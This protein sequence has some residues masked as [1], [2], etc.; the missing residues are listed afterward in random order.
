MANAR[1]RGWKFNKIYKVSPF[2]REPFSR[3]LIER[4]CGVAIAAKEVRAIPRHQV[5][6]QFLERISYTAVSEDRSSFSVATRSRVIFSSSC[7]MR[8]A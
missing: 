3:P 6:A 2:F 5:Q 4:D 7:G 1:L 8:F